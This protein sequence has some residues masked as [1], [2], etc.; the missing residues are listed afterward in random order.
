MKTV[1]TL[2]AI[3]A[4]A[5][6]LAVSGPALAHE[7]GGACR[8]DLQA[9]CPN[10]TPGPGAFKGCLSTL[11]PDVT[12]GP[13][14]FG[15]CLNEHASQLSTACQEQLS[16]FQSKMAE[17][18]QAFQQA[19]GSDAQTYCADA[20]GPHATFKCLHDNKDQLS[21]G[22]QSFLAEHHHHR[23][24]RHHHHRCKPTPSPSTSSSAS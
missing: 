19:C 7:H 15:K 5:V 6:A 14:A 9:L 17:W 11:C 8:Q 12:P 3:A 24:H 1:H 13:G 4:F 18:K 2:T 22:C 20:S 21:E 16:Q 23:H 10:V